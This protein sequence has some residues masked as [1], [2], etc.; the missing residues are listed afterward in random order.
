MR[1]PV[2]N[3]STEMDSAPR[4]LDGPSGGGLATPV[5]SGKGRVR[6]PGAPRKIVGH[7]AAWLSLAGRG[8][9]QGEE[10]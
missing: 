7:G 2:S 6:N 9:Q 5:A 3:T 10:P 8:T 4:L 1:T